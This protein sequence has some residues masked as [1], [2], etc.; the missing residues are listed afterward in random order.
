MCTYVIF[1]FPEMVEKGFSVHAEITLT[2]LL[3]FCPKQQWALPALSLAFREVLNNG[4][5]SLS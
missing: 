2:K 5:E 4:F 1:F 3:Y